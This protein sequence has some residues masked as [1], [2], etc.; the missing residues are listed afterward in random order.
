M[1][2]PQVAPPKPSDHVLEAEV[3]EIEYAF[4][5]IR[6]DGIPEIH[7]KKLTAKPIPLALIADAV[8]QHPS[9]ELEI[10]VLE[11]MKYPVILTYNTK[12]EYRDAAKGLSNA[13]GYSDSKPFLTI[14]GN[15]RTEIARRNDFTHI[16]AF[17]VDTGREAVIVKKV[18]DDES[19]IK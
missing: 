2:Q 10:S 5:F 15:Q 13:S 16:D 12:D 9:T 6:D 3:K 17:I 11:E 1:N 7:N 8:I 19:A 4:F 18:Y 14:I